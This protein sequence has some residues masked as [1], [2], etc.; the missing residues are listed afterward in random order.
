[1]RNATQWRFLEDLGI[2]QE[3]LMNLSFYTLIVLASKIKQHHNM[4][5]VEY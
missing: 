3:S 4:R 5:S 2:F 1:M